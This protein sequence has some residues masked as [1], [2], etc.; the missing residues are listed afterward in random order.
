LIGGDLNFRLGSSEILGPVAQLHTLVYL[1]ISRMKEIGLFDIQPIKISPTWKNMCMREERVSKQLDRFLISKSLHEEN[2]Q[3]CQWVSFG[4]KSDHN[5]IILELGPIMEKPSNIF[6]MILTW[7]EDLY[8]IDM[9]KGCWEIY[10]SSSMKSPPLQFLSNI[11]K[12]KEPMISW[13]KERKNKENETLLI[14][15]QRYKGVSIGVDMVY[16]QISIKRR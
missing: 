9:I 1:F 16:F 7:L 5:P 10:D 15:K 14:L 13:N 8:F 2:L 12:V 11:K 4:V 6:N 3:I